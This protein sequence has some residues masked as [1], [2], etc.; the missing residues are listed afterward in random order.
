MHR[1]LLAMLAWVPTLTLT[2]TAHAAGLNDTGIGFCGDAGSNT[3]SCA[4]VAADS[5]AYPRQDAR[6]GRDAAAAAGQLSKAG[7]G[8]AGFDFTA[9]DAAG[10]PATPAS[11]A[12]PHPCVKD[13]NTGLVWEVKTDAGGL[14][15]QNWT[16]TWY[17]SA[18]NYG[19]NPG[20]ADGG[21]C[22][23]PGRCDTEKYVADVNAT[24][25]CGY[26]NWRL[27]TVKELEGIVHYGRSYPAIDPAY[28]PNTP[29]SAFWSGSPC[30]YN[31]DGS[32]YVYF[33]YGYANVDGRSDEGNSVRLVRG[34]K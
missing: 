25:L 23:S 26:T 6:Y 16:Y 22:K 29:S 5:G 27:P 14:R 7:G 33:G 17:D 11:G 15:D 3:A 9:L 31:S 19:G 2:V 12:N 30:A 13:N 1:V 24:A 32:W 18:H 20:M 10:Q 34:G 8:E 28:F 4:T 21:N